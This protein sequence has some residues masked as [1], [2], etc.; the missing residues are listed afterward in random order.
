MIRDD[1][2]KG[3]RSGFTLIELLV[4]IAIIAIL[5][6]ILLPA[7]A[8]AKFRSLLAS[9]K[10]NHRQL[11]L[12][13]TMY[14]GDFK[15]YTPAA[16]YNNG[17]SGLSPARNQ[18]PIGT[19]IGGGRF[20]WDS[21]GGALQ[22]YLS[23]EAQ[24][25]WRDPGASHGQAKIDDIWEWSGANPQSGYASDDVFRPNY[26][27]MSTA[28]WIQLPPSPAWFPERWATRNIAN[29][30]ASTIPSPGTR[31]LFVCESTSQHTGNQ[32]IYER[33]AARVNPPRPDV[34]NFSYLDGHVEQKKFV[35]LH[36]YLSALSEA[37]PQS[38]F[39]ISFEN[40]PNWPLRDNLPEPIR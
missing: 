2:V 19:P 8:Q 4:V 31:V 32:D 29:L 15:D 24:R 34:E 38:Q 12:A 22:P 3:T 9:C 6:G 23:G 40:T 1:K 11:C 5:A 21:I 33:Y 25:L 28:E 39:G 27:Y 20:V 7:L 37:I 35:D 18:A 16:T 14:F 30:P 26:F 17:G 36:G 13:A 10:N